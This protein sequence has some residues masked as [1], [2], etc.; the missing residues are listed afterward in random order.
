MWNNRGTIRKLASAPAGT[1]TIPIP[2]VVLPAD[3][4][5]IKHQA[6]QFLWIER[7][8]SFLQCFPLAMVRA[9]DHQNTVAGHADQFEIGQ[10]K[11][12]RRIDENEFEHFAAMCEEFLPARA[13][14]KFRWG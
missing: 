1:V 9:H 2:V 13:R 11:N 7:S 4:R 10:R 12:R 8:G 3:I 5:G 14:K 6:E